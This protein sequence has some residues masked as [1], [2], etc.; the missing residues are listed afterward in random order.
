[1]FHVR[2]SGDHVIAEVH[3]GPAQWYP[4]D[5]S[6]QPAPHYQH[7]AGPRSETVPSAAT[8]SVKRVR[9]SVT[10]KLRFLPAERRLW[11]A[12]RCT[13]AVVKT[14][15]TEWQ[16]TATD[17]VSADLADRCSPVSD[18]AHFPAVFQPS[19]SAKKINK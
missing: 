8:H 7:A 12:A 4:T 18:C 10:A 17:C 19:K 16:E 2:T 13:A 14:F 15:A 3:C 5:S 6:H 1:M 11:T 9:H